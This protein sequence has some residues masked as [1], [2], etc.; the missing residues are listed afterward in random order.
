MKGCIFDFKRYSV[1]DGPGIRF[2]VF[3]KGCPLHCAWCH[4]PESQSFEPQVLFIANKCIGCGSCESR[5]FPEKC[6]AKALEKCGS[7]YT[8]E[9][10]MK[11][12]RR[13]IPFFERSGGGVTFSGGEPMAQPQILLELLKECRASGIHTAVDTSLFV[14]PGVLSDIIPFTDLFLLDLKVMNNERHLKYIGVENGLILEN[15]HTVARS[16][17]PFALRIPFIGGVNDNQQEINAML[18]LALELSNLGNLTRIHILP[19]HDYGRSKL[20]RINPEAVLPPDSFYKPSDETI[21]GA[22]LLFA[23]QGFTVVQGG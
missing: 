6:P 5:Q 11:R 15:M 16:Q 9:Q 21:A 17:V 14:N 4:N 1:H 10:V 12:I 18:Q 7:W 19:Y 8:V 20:I 2:S 22:M 23:S 3:F 13:E